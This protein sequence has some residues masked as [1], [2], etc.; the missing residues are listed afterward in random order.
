MNQLIGRLLTVLVALCVSFGAVSQERLRF[1]VVDFSE[2]LSDFSARDPQYE[3][4]DNNG[5]RY[6][7]IK[8]RSINPGDNLAE[9]NFNFGNMRHIT[10]MHDDVLWIY[11]Q[12][13]AKQVTIQR[14]GYASVNRYDLHTTIREGKNYVMTLS[15]EDKKVLTQMTQFSINP[16]VANATILI[17]PA[18]GQEEVFG[19][20]DATGAVAKNLVY[21]TYA[22]K[23]IAPNYHLSEGQ[24]TLDNKDLTHVETVNLRSNAGELTLVVDAPAEIW[25]NGEKKGVRQWSGKLPARQY[26]V[27]CRQPNH[28]PSS[29][30]I[31]VSENDRRTITLAKPQP[32]LGTLSVSSTPLGAM[33]KVDGTEYGKTPRNIDMVIGQH[34]VSIV[35]DGYTEYSTP[36]TVE[37]DKT[38]TVNATLTRGVNVTIKTS[39]QYSIDVYVDGERLYNDNSYKYNYRGQV[40]NHRIK[41]KYDGDDYRGISRNVYIGRSTDLYFSLPENFLKKLD[42]YIEGN[43]AYAGCFAGGA[44]MGF[45]IAGFNAE[46]FLYGGIDSGETLRWYDVS[47]GNPNSIGS[48]TYKPE[49][50]WGFKAG[51]AFNVAGRLRITPQL[52]FMGVKV[53]ESDG[54][55]SR[56]SS[57]Y[58]Q[59]SYRGSFT[60]GCRFFVATAHHFGISLTPEYAISAGESDGFKILSEASSK[61]K[62]YGEGFSIKLGLAVVF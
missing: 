17:T 59:N 19:N 2:D 14:P 31:E 39:P 47:T 10:Q 24:F 35:A 13:N 34:T 29:Q 46:G 28:T 1:H 45:H 55:D 25:I 53:R 41:I 27:E 15:A 11:V 42:C 6:A 22:Y 58:I 56:Y 57:E 26:T 20:T 12:K 62:H 61:I 4:Y 23:V 5:N 60:A 52:G 37:K 50:L 38:A 8:V 9:Y 36:V 33:I 49:M 3:Q 43:I 54:E 16:P 44:T 18:G 30:Y 51:Y 32:I 48:K 21:G 40:G 7:I